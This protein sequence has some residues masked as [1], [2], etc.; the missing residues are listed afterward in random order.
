MGGHL[1][2]AI[3]QKEDS[4]KLAMAGTEALKAQINNMTDE[5]ERLKRENTELKKEAEKLENAIINK[6]NKLERRVN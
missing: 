4:I 3:K 5:K 2:D 1:K 6:I